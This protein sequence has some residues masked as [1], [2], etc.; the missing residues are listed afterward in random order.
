MTNTN[1]SR[2]SPKVIIIVLLVLFGAFAVFTIYLV[3][4]TPVKYVP[5]L[6]DKVSDKVGNRFYFEIPSDKVLKERFIKNKEAY[7]T[8]CKMAKADGID[9]LDES[10]LVYEDG[11]VPPQF[12]PGTLGGKLKGKINHA[13]FLEYHQLLSDC[14]VRTVSRMFEKRGGVSGVAFLVY[15]SGI[16][17]LNQPFTQKYVA[18]F[19]TDEFPVV[20]NTDLALPDKDGLVNA[21][22]K[23]APHWYIWRYSFKPEDKKHF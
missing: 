21:L 6:I 1:S 23:I 3:E 7:E 18:R 11:H 5:E 8:L 12:M 9:R 22:V 20:E 19:D 16:R 14:K 10:Q 13:R 17:G 2:N 15:A 4:N